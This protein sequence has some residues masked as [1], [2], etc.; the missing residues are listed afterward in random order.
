MKSLFFTTCNIWGKS[1][2]HNLQI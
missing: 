1:W 2:S